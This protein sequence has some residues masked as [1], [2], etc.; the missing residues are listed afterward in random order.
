[1]EEWGT[2]EK[3][4]LSQGRGRVFHPSSRT[5]MVLIRPAVSAFQRSLKSDLRTVDNPSE[6]DP[7]LNI[8]PFIRNSALIS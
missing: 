3:S 1:M 6:K 5:I 4:N 7:H 2:E 8:Q